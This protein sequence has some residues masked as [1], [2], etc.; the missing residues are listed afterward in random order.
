MAIGV[1]LPAGM[2]VLGWSYR[3]EE[4]GRS[5][6]ARFLD[7]LRPT[8]AGARH[9]S[10]AE[11]LDQT[12]PLGVGPRDQAEAQARVERAQRMERDGTGRAVAEAVD[13]ERS[14]VTEV[15]QDVAGGAR[16]PLEDVA[17]ARRE[18]VT[19]ISQGDGPETTSIID[20]GLVRRV[21]GHAAVIDQ[22]G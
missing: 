11:C 13:G 3:A 20:L 8:A 16:H 15:G 10:G 12:C 14:A 1:L 19:V 2:P 17:L 18:P 7:R 4:P 21:E 5:S 22:P 9:G 6:P